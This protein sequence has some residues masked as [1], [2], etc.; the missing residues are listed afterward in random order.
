MLVRAVIHISLCFLF[1]IREQDEANIRHQKAIM[2]LQQELIEEKV[3]VQ[4][5]LLEK[6]Q[7]ETQLLED[8]KIELEEKMEKKLKDIEKLVG[9]IANAS[10][11]ASISASSSPPA[12]VSATTSLANT[13]NITTSKY[14]FHVT[15]RH[16][17]PFVPKSALSAGT[18][19]PVVMVYAK[20]GHGDYALADQTT[21][22]RNDP[23]PNFKEP[24]SLAM[25]TDLPNE[26]R[27]RVFSFDPSRGTEVLND[28]IIGSAKVKLADVVRNNT[29]LE[30]PLCDEK[31]VT[32]SVFQALYSFLPP[33]D[34]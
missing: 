27:F 14:A 15:C 34:I 1:G 8:R 18:C 32:T 24:I 2:K 10:A 17:P 11:S 12:V 20:D 7:L 30:V 16:L 26:F 6:R 9:A 21:W 28:H 33:L 13:P 4:T 22:L 25:H 5:R 3:S 23:S 29:W 19:D 31:V